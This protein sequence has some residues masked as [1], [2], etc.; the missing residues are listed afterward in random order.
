M[1]SKH[2]EAIAD[3]IRNNIHSKN[4]QEEIARALLS[5]LRE[6]NPRFDAIR[7]M[8]AAVGE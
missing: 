2:F 5:A 4:Q 1:S 6:S 8:L 3:A 7:F